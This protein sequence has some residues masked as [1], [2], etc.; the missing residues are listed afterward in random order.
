MSRKYYK[1]ELK[2]ISEAA[3]APLLEKEGFQSY[4]NDLLNWFRI[5][6]KAGIVQHFHLLLMS[7]RWCS[8]IMYY[9]GIHPTYLIAP[10]N[11]GFD[12]NDFGGVY[13]EEVLTK[14]FSPVPTHFTVP[15]WGAGINV[16]NT[17]MMGAE[18]LSEFFFPLFDEIKTREAAYALHIKRRGEVLEAYKNTP[19]PFVRVSADFIDEAIYYEDRSYYEV[20][21]KSMP[22]AIERAKAAEI[23]K[24]SALAPR[25]AKRQA[26]AEKKG[27]RSVGEL[28]LQLRTLQEGTEAEYRKHLE[29]REQAYVIKLEKEFGN[30]RA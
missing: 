7:A 28:E 10:F 16:P 13:S 2:K 22:R 25:G 23:L 24:A 4:R 30:T 12:F 1:D 14:N 6:L 11:P 15:P 3:Y 29:Q 27:C 17:P 19:H 20:A 26:A 18:Q 8:R 5:D 21:L 9:F